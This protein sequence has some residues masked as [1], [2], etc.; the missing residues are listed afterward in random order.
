M[1]YAKLASVFVVA[2]LTL[3]LAACSPTRTQKS[4]GEQVDD[5]VILGKVNAALILEP[6][7]KALQIDVEVFRGIVQLNGFVVSGTER[8][9]AVS[10]ARG[11][12]GVKVVRNNLVIDKQRDTLGSEIDDTAITARVKRALADSAETSAMRL[13]VRTANGRVLLGGFANSR[14]E[15]DAAARIARSVSEVKTVLNEIDVK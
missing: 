11:V 15:K 13:N 4:F 2:A 10:V 12:A 5:T 14:A 7:T 9:R 3:A 6:N 8:S 1:T